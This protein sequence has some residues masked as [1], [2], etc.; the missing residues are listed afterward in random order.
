MNEQ[1]LF[2]LLLGT[3]ITNLIMIIVAIILFVTAEE[4]IIN[5]FEAPKNR[6]RIFRMFGY[7][8]TPTTSGTPV[9]VSK[10]PQDEAKE[11]K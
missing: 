7:G 10:G 11:P 3:F 8:K 4:R 1:I 6:L 2:W 5:F 9:A